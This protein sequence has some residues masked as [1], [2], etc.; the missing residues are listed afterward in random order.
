MQTIDLMMA[1]VTDLSLS[2]TSVLSR[3][4]ITC[5]IN[6]LLEIAY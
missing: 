2:T 6:M 1:N 5:I 4:H 3:I